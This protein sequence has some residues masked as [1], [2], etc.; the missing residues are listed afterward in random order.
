[1][2]NEELE[3]EEFDTPTDEIENENLINWQDDLFTVLF[4]R[5]SDLVNSDGD[6]MEVWPFVD[7]GVPLSPAFRVIQE[8]IDS[9]FSDDPDDSYSNIVDI[10]CKAYML[11]AYV[12]SETAYRDKYSLQLTNEQISQIVKTFVNDKINEGL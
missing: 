2:E 12:M 11:G 3:S 8:R 10:A 4:D 7:G 1:M 5:V 6:V 9:A